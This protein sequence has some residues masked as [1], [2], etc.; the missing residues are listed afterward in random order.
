MA[1]QSGP[2]IRSIPPGLISPPQAGLLVLFPSS[3][4]HAVTCNDEDDELRLSVSFDLVMTAPASASGPG[5][6]SGTRAGAAPEY[7]SPHPS[8]WTAMP[9]P[10]GLAIRE[11]GGTQIACPRAPLADA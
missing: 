7:L 3:T 2:A 11:D 4:D 5:A 10:V 8:D 1:A 9:A 6:G